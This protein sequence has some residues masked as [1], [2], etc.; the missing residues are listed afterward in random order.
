MLYEERI[1]QIYQNFPLI[2]FP[3]IDAEVFSIYAILLFKSIIDPRFFEFSPI[4]DR[5]ID[6]F[7]NYLMSD[8]KQF[9]FLENNFFKNSFGYYFGIVYLFLEPPIIKQINNLKKLILEIYTYDREKDQNIILSNRFDIINISQ[10]KFDE[11]QIMNK[12]SPMY[13]FYIIEEDFYY[14]FYKQ[15]ID[16]YFKISPNSTIDTVLK[17]YLSPLEVQDSIKFP[18]EIY[19]RETYY[20]QNKSVYDFIMEIYELVFDFKNFPVFYKL[21]GFA[22]KD[23]KFIIT[24]FNKLLENSKFINLFTAYETLSPI[25]YGTKHLDYSEDRI[26][27]TFVNEKDL[28]YS[29]SAYLYSYDKPDVEHKFLDIKSFSF[30]LNKA[31][32]FSYFVSYNSMTRLSLLCLFSLHL[33][34]SDENRRFFSQNLS[35]NLVFSERFLSEKDYFK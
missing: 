32:D 13:V 19:E 34:K 27:M 25:Y 18:N 9:K 7:S 31:G 35:Y 23:K 15:I 8:E 2:K 4:S 1:Q 22:R 26:I 24:T 33:L 21:D 30:L 14:K 20:A 28:S 29:D 10:Q 6:K 12:S 5:Y 11:T 17:K 16:E 3:E